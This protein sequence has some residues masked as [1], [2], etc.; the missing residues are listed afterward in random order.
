MIEVIGSRTLTLGE[1]E[2]RARELR[3]AIGEDSLTNELR[4]V[5]EASLRICPSCGRVGVDIVCREHATD[6][7]A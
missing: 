3:E 2:R 7:I 5:G 6:A 4:A 1:L